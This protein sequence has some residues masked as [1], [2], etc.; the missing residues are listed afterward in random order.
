MMQWGT[1]AATCLHAIDGSVWA[2]QGRLSLLLQCQ[3]MQTKYGALGHI[4]VV[5]SALFMKTKAGSFSAV[6]SMMW[7]HT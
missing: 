3:L 6:F 4:D 1:N 5:V 7:N 2:L